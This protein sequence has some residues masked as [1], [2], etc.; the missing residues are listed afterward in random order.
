MNGKLKIVSGVVVF[1][2]IIALVYVVKMG[3]DADRWIDRCADETSGEYI[4][5]EAARTATC[6]TD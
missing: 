2:M 4:A 3:L 5:D 1:G 6:A